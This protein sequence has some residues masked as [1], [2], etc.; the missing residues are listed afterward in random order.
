MSV[1]VGALTSPM[2]PE[3][4]LW[5]RFI[6]RGSP[7]VVISSRCP[8]LAL[9]ESGGHLDKSLPEVEIWTN[10]DTRWTSGQIAT[11]GGYLDKS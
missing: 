10:S 3:V 9:V 1:G 6:P 11:S 8:P 2:F 4:L 5:P 7:L